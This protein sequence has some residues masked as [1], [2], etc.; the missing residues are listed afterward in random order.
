[1][2]GHV[3]CAIDAIISIRP[4]Y[5]DAILAGSKTVELRRRVP[6][7]A[8]G[9]RLWIYATRPVAAIV[10]FATIKHVAKSRPSAIWRAHRAKAGIDHAAFKAYFNG[11]DCAVAIELGN[12]RRTDPISLEQLRCIRPRFHPPQVLM[13]LTAAETRALRNL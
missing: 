7:V 11:T 9:T 12:A 5:A 4:A 6:L 13:H 10:G 8:P 3:R 1:L 2:D